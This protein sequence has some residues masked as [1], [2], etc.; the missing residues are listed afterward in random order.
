MSV[1]YIRSTNTKNGICL[2]A[3]TY[4]LAL[5][6]VRGVHT[7]VLALHNLYMY[8]LVCYLSMYVLCKITFSYEYFFVVIFGFTSIHAQQYSH[9]LYY[10]LFIKQHVCLCVWVWVI[11]CK[12][13]YVRSSV[14][15]C[16]CMCV[17]NCV[18]VA[19]SMSTNMCPHRNLSHHL[20]F[21]Y[22]KCILLEIVV[23]I[24]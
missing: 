21:M 6:Y 19:V 12:Y 20:P 22:Q 14:C 11:K 16:V 9:T 23:F 5:A 10:Y 4:V 3:L 8:K 15:I 2:C 7:C 18:F 1:S 13:V 24:W 17:S